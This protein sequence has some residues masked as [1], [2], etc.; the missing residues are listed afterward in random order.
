MIERN[1]KGTRQN[2]AREDA[3]VTFWRILMLLFQ[4]SMDVT[5]K[6]LSGDSKGYRIFRR[7][8]RTYEI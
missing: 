6:A 8:K 5:L 7:Y 3:D 4:F 2:P 1:E